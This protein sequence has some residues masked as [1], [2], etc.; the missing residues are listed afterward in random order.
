MKH[1]IESSV[2]QIRS[3]LAGKQAM[4]NYLIFSKVN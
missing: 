4:L 3:L 2:L 1:K